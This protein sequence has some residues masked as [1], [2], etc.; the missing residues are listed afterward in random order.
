M[1]NTIY[2]I[3]TIPQSTNKIQLEETQ[4]NNFLIYYAAVL[5]RWSRRRGIR[6]VSDD[7]FLKS[8]N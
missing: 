8:Y 6:H 7:G 2:L 3:I 1:T 4:P 5:S